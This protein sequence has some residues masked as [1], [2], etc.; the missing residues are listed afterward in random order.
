MRAALLANGVLQSAADENVFT[1]DYMFNSPSTAAAVVLGRIAN[2]RIE[3]KTKNGKT[4]KEI[5]E[6]QAQE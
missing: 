3:W 4:L 2:G 1:Q 6:A 5:Q